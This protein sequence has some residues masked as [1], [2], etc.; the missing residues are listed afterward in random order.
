MFSLGV[1]MTAASNQLTGP[2][3]HLFNRGVHSGT[4][5]SGLV[6]SHAHP[7][8]APMGHGNQRVASASM[9]A[10]YERPAAA[11]DVSTVANVSCARFQNWVPL[12]GR[13]L[14]P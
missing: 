13:F 6:A 12:R 7:C 8:R 14:G 4:P 1:P 10:T 2:Q 9:N 3:Q 5:K 11:L